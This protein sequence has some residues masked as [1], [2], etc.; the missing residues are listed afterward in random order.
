LFIAGLG[1]TRGYLRRPEL[2]AERFLPDPF[3]TVPGAQIYRT[4]DRVRWLADGQIQYLGRLDRQ[5]KLRGYRIELGEVEHVMLQHPGVAAAAVEVP[6]GA[7]VNH[8][9]NGYFVERPD[10]HVDPAEL[11]AT[12]R[13]KLPEHMVPTGFVRLEALP[14]NGSGK[15]DRHALQRMQPRAGEA[16]DE[17]YVAPTNETEDRIAKIWAAVL[18][19]GRVGIRQRFFDLGGHSLLATRVIF[20]LG[21]AFGIDLPLRAIF[22]FPTVAELAREVERLKL[23]RADGDGVALVA[24][25][26]TVMTLPLDAR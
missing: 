12:L 25:A 8:F 18:E 11:R 4:G 3:Q 7:N 14:L 6:A 17:Q 13:R 22:E 9:L 5:L 1:V 20:R 24:R 16:C 21:E 26:R 15:L 10:S 19:T 2:T 23:E